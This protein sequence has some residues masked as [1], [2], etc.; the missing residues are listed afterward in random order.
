MCDLIVSEPDR[1]LS[2]YLER[3]PSNVC[4]L[5]LR[6]RTRNHRLPVETGRWRGIALTDRKCHLCNLDIGDKFHYLLVCDFLN[7]HRRKYLKAYYY[8]RPNTL[9]REQL[10][11]TK[12]VK[13]LTNLCI[14]IKNIVREIS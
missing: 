3:L 9:K 13:I 4:K 8:K 2:F 12:N 14:F 1:C 5:F 6:F 11:N 7:T 10:M